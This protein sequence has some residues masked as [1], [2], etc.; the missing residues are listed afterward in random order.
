MVDLAVGRGLA[1]Y[2][3][4]NGVEFWP[5]KCFRYGKGVPTLAPAR[6]TP[7][8]YP[9][10]A[11]HG[12]LG[13]TGGGLGVSDPVE[14][15]FTALR[16]INASGAGVSEVSYYGAL[17]AL[18]NE[19]GKGLKPKVQAVMQL[20]NM[21]AGNPDGGLFPA[22]VVKAGVDQT[23][24]L[25]GTPWRCAIEVKGTR[26]DA[27]AIAESEQVRKYVDANSDTK[28]TTPRR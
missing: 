17:E 2:D 24:L 26:D 15:Y 13:H 25:G 27:F 10:H 6:V 12:D 11:E 18:L 23:T 20:K 7:A 16:D 1:P 9:D 8:C 3:V 5:V 4:E 28:C 19:V 22:N 14:A 21:G